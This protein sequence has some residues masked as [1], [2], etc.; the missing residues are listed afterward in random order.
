MTKKNLI[1][2]KKNNLYPYIN[3]YS[4]KITLT[5]TLFPLPAKAIFLFIFPLNKPYFYS[6]MVIGKKNIQNQYYH[7]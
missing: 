2:I 4:T 6:H 7:N 5:K 1:L 3:F